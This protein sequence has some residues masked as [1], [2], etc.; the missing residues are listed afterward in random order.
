MSNLSNTIEANGKSVAQNRRTKQIEKDA[1]NINNEGLTKLQVIGFKSQETMR[2][3]IDPKTGKTLM[4]LKKER[5]SETN[6]VKMK[7]SGNPS[8]GTKLMNN[9]LINKRV[10]KD[11]LQSFIDNGWNLGAI[12]KAA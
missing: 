10:K 11:E 3:T 1:L 9:G 5:I 7:G 4:Q 2:N 12:K 8:F 6:K